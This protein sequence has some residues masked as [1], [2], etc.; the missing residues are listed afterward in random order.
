MLEEL[1]T[2]KK[3]REE[4]REI[5]RESKNAVKAGGQKSE[6]FWTYKG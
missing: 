5:Y 4:I 6:E 3:L 2:S 1:G